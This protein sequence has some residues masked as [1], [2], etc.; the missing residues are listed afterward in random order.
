MTKDNVCYITVQFISG[1]NISV[2]FFE[3]KLTFFR[4]ADD[5]KCMSLL[6]LSLI[7]KF[8]SVAWS[9]IHKW[10]RTGGGWTRGDL[11]VCRSS[12]R[13][14]CGTARLHCGRTCSCEW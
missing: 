10:I 6:I 8:C 3:F 5:I 4:I 7:V 14:D 13:G 2:N 11:P 12:L 9:A 1:M